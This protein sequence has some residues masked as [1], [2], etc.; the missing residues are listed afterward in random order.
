MSA[1]PPQYESDVVLRDGSTLRLR[2]VRPDDAGRLI[3]MFE[4]M[5][6]ESLYF[7]FFN[8]PRI[9]S[10][11]AAQLAT[12]DYEDQFAL[13]GEIGGAI[14]ALAGYYRGDRE[15]ERA[16][17]A[18]AIADTLQGRG[19]GTKLLERLALVA[20]QHRIETFDAYVLADN[21]RM[22]DVF[23][24]SGFDVHRRLDGGVV[25]FVLALRETAEFQKRSLDRAQKA[26]SASMKV[27]FEPRSVAVIGANRRRGEIG[28]EIFHNLLASGFT[29]TAIPINPSAAEIMGVR[30]YPRLQ[31]VP[32][33]V[34]LAVIAVP[35]RAVAG[36]VDDCI[37][38]GV[39]AVVVI[40][41]GFGETGTEGRALEAEL[42][43]KIR[44]AGIRM[45][46]PN[47]MGIL[48]ADPAVRMNAT[49][50]PVYPPEG[51]VAMATQ[52][53]ALGLAILAYARRLNI[54]IS[55]FVSMGNKADVSGNDLI[56]YWAE[57]PRTRVILLYLES[58]GN[59]RRFGQIARHVA[60]QKPIVAVKAGR[61]SAGARAASSHTGAHASSDTI[62]DALFRQAGVIRTGTLEELFDISSLLAHQPPPRGPRVGILTNAGGPGILAA[63]ACEAS[64]LEIPSL[65]DATVAELRS[66]LPPTASVA[67]P[68][69]MIA[70][71]SPDHYRRAMRAMLTDDRVDSLI[72][73]FIPPLVTE[74]EEVAAA[75]RDGATA[76]GEKP[77]LATFMS[78]QGAP[79]VLEPIPCYTFPESAA[80]ALARVTAYGAWQRRPE[81]TIPTFADVRP[82]LAR[83]VVDRVLARGG[84]WLFPA[85]AQ[86]VLTAFGIRVAAVRTATGE[87]E[88]VAA[89]SALGWPVAM[90]AVG[91][92][93]IHKTDVG[94][95]VL[96]LGA[97]G[98]VRRAY[99]DLRDR[100][101][102]ALSGVLLQEMVAG[103]VE[104][105]V[106]TVQDSTFGPLVA[107]GSG[108]VLVDV[109]RDTVFRISPLAD[110]D[111]DQMLKDVRG[112][113][114][115]RGYRGAAPADEAA[116][117][118][119]L[120][121]VSALQEACPEIQEMDINPVKVLAH[122]ACALDVR[123]RVDH[124]L[125][126]PRS[127]R[128]AY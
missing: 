99:R 5:S 25:H 47:C 65:G 101:G 85:E 15:P 108:G 53:G 97:E 31:D 115:L 2:P 62:V 49:F 125:A 9:D 20:R 12:V 102:E 103:G 67:N 124:P 117:R 60:K 42:V 88:A 68:V 18:F 105:L 19:L 38:K 30:A 26:A 91:P 70:S 27:F 73:I 106:G 41:A 107:C 8:M 44:G 33:S 55:T 84:G 69:D 22:V 110:V 36:V 111:A 1:Y 56:Q 120:L 32:G 35:A 80:I 72:V 126:V 23:R 37:E 4:V 40:S 3:E 118:D 116:L 81:G 29:G 93:I 34:D 78:A 75:I 113:V 14:G 83:A 57:D 59:P 98:D 90:K 16:E 122:G 127:R 66:F 123:I 77:V 94:G 24:D 112:A 95:V 17:V 128:V 50:S 76:A 104:M 21:R 86:E 58:F 11:R 10:K 71:A 46:G 52:S 51:Q 89:A 92:T 13:V 63:D 39:R 96:G 114:L 87:D 7:R 79:A 82:D 119:V 121:R 74:P 61:S 48:N 45:I 43:D 109:L 64:G 28:G 100:L 6:P 54:G